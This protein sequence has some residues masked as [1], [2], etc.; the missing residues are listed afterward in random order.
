MLVGVEQVLISM[1]NP[2]LMGLVSLARF[3]VSALIQQEEASTL[4]FLQLL[5]QVCREI[6]ILSTPKLVFPRFAYVSVRASEPSI[7]KDI[8]RH[9]P[10]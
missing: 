8:F 10:Q 1:V 9:S 6:V 4:R 2:G 7:A 5:E 3:C